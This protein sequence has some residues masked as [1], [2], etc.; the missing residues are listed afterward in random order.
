MGCGCEEAFLVMS[1]LCWALVSFRL[2]GSWSCICWAVVMHRLSPVLGLV[3]YLATRAFGG[4]VVYL[5][6]F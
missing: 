5:R 6:G 4:T 3:L 1:W 2:P